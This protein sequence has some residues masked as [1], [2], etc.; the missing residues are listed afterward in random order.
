MLLDIT[1]VLAVIVVGMTLAPYVKRL[2]NRW[3]NR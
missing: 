2:I 3:R 1:V